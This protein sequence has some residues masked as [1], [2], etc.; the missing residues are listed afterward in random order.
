VGFALPIHTPDE[1]SHHPPFPKLEFPK[2]D[3]T[4]P[5]LWWDQCEVYFEVYAVQEAMKTR[6][7]SLNFKGSVATWLQSVEHH[8]QIREWSKLCDTVTAKYDKDQYQRISQ[9]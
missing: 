6:F 7:A 4:N 9:A 2:F 5:R 1:S 3:G 8:G